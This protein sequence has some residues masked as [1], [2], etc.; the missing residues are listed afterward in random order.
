MSYYKYLN[1]YS[2]GFLRKY[3][4]GTYSQLARSTQFSEIVEMNATSS[5]SL[6]EDI[7]MNMSAPYNFTNFVAFMC[8]VYWYFYHVDMYAA[9]SYKNRLRSYHNYKM[10][11]R[12]EIAINK[13]N[14]E[15]GNIF[16]RPLEDRWLLTKGL[17]RDQFN[18]LNQRVSDGEDVDEILAAWGKKYNFDEDTLVDA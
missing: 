5:M 13:S 3:Q 16:R 17:T 6:D 12:L 4:T 8:I 10:W 9:S 7:T 1:Q 15:A 14:V 18:Q 11:S 2:P